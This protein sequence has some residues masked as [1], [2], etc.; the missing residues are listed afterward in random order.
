MTRRRTKNNV[1]RRRLKKWE[2][3]FYCSK[4]DSVISCE[5]CHGIFHGT[6][7]ELASKLKDHELRGKLVGSDFI[8][9]VIEYG[10]RDGSVTWARTKSYVSG[11]QE[12]GRWVEID[13]NMWFRE[14]IDQKSEWIY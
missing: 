10:H 6:V 2:R 12:V 13:K 4:H 5:M 3:K 1:W 9:D 8:F 11:R 7:K 14:E